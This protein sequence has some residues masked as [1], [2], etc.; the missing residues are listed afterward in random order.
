MGT[1]GSTNSCTNKENR[2]IYNHFCNEI[3]PATIE[4][5]ERLS[6]NQLAKKICLMFVL[7]GLKL[8]KTIEKTLHDI[9]DIMRAKNVSFSF[10][11]KQR[12]NYIAGQTT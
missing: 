6:N 8:T 3:I 7:Q 10:F 5:G 12:E 4:T 11:L 2:A 1:V 9:K